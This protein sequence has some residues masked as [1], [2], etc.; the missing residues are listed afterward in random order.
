MDKVHMRLFYVFILSL[1]LTGCAATRYPAP[2]NHAQY[3]PC[4]PMNAQV[5]PAQIE[6]SFIWPVKGGVISSFGN[7][8]GD[9]RNKG[10]DI[11]AGQGDTV[12]AAASGRV[13]YSDT[14][15]RGFGMTVIIDHGDN[16]QTVYAYNSEILVKPGDDVMQGD[17]IAKAGSSGRAKEPCLHFEVRKDGEPVDPIGYLR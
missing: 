1:S 7:K 13:V 6:I 4:Q 17:A 10:I 14:K 5:P 11:K 15:M 2:V 9:F 12:R 16:V 3:L 8:S